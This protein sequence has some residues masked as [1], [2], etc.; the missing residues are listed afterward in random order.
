MRLFLST[1]FYHHLRNMYFLPP[2]LR[3]LFRNFVQSVFKL[4]TQP[5]RTFKWPLPTDMLQ[6]AIL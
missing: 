4:P 1:Q 6:D 3:D 5:T 2:R